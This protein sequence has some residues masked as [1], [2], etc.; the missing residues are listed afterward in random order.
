MVR[1]AA[2]YISVSSTLTLACQIRLYSISACRAELMWWVM[3]RSVGRS[4]KGL[5][6]QLNLQHEAARP[7]GSKLIDK[8]R[9]R[10]ERYCHPSPLCMGTLN[11][12]H[13]GTPCGPQQTPPPRGV[14][15]CDVKCIKSTIDPVI[16]SNWS[17]WLR[18]SIFVK[19]VL[20]ERHQISPPPRGFQWN[21]WQW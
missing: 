9:A 5:P 6:P 21:S 7:Y 13:V 16:P 18:F 11:T 17:S 12:I 10:R 15:R 19:L 2:S 3:S 14:S 20:K 1:S 8:Q 4:D